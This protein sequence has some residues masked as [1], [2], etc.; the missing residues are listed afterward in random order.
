MIYYD[1]AIENAKSIG[2]K[3]ALS[4]AYSSKISLHI[5]REQHKEIYELL[6][7][8][9]EL[10]ISFPNSKSWI[11]YYE[12]NAYIAFVTADYYRAIDYMD[13]TIIA[14]NR[15]NY[16]TLIHETYEHLGFCYNKI[17]DYEKSIENFIKSLALKEKYGYVKDIG[18]TYR[19]LGNTYLEW[20]HYDKAKYFFERAI[21]V[22]RQ[23][24]HR[25]SLISNYRKLGQCNRILGLNHEAEKAIDSSLALAKIAQEKNSITMNLSEKGLLYFENYKNNQKAEE[26]FKKAH[27][28]AKSSKDKELLFMTIRDLV[29]LYFVKKEYAKIG[30]KL[31]DLVIIEKQINTAR[32][33]GYL[34]KI[35]AQ[36]YEETNQFSKALLKSKEYHKLNDSIMDKEVFEKMAILDKRYDTQ[37][38]ELQI[39]NLNK[40]KEAQKQLTQQAKSQQNLYLLA[41]VFFLLLLV[42][43]AW[44]FR[45]LRKQQKELV[46]TNQ[47]KNRLFS[48]IAHDLR[49]MMIPF[50]RSGKILKHHIDKGN[51]QKTIELSQAIE[52][53][54]ESL[55][56]MLDN[57][58]NWSLEQ[59]N[60][61]KMN[62]EKIAVSEELS[63]IIEGYEQQATYK[64]TKIELKYT[65][66]I[67]VNMDKGAFHVIF[68]NLIGNALKYTEE[69]NIRIEFKNEEGRFLC[70]IVDTG[71]GMSS[72]QLTKLFTLEEK[73]ATVGTQGE[74]G[75]GLGL[76][77]VYRFIKMHDGTIQVLSEKRIGTRFDLSIPIT[78]ALTKEKE[79]ISESL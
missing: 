63:K 21:S 25:L 66:D 6:K 49:G 24:N 59:M 41:A 77:L 20:K 39:T 27:L 48:I 14:A 43:G 3:E 1:K 52:Q 73:K 26:Y 61:Y 74:K 19:N 68:R 15:S 23:Q 16:K 2:A 55:S 54:S 29:V 60:G 78:I 31:E 42:I 10:I 62:P 38:K 36:Y 46:S 71:V 45:K 8:S 65:E 33:K 35:Q 11:K 13:S 64:K 17:G 9:R 51:H 4:Y 30:K 67:A 79:A 58:L 22:T 18:G 34:L 57:L 76:N 37:K 40:E 47:V 50:Q 69:G 5:R 53:N 28:S 56:S 72:D 32:F 12:Q 70:S 7:K 44:A 75:T